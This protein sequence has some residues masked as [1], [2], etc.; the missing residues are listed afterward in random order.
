[1]L[2]K[3]HHLAKHSVEGLRMCGIVLYYSQPQHFL[4]NINQLTKVWPFSRTLTTMNVGFSTSS[5]LLPAGL[6]NS[7]FCLLAASSWATIGSLPSTRGGRLPA[8]S[9][10]NADRLFLDWCWDSSPC[11]VR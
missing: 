1:M 11:D 10:P 8:R 2:K 6:H 9:E 5:S 4:N 7:S 3:F